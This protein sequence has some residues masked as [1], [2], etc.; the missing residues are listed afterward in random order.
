MQLCLKIVEDMMEFMEVAMVTNYRCECVS[1]HNLHRLPCHVHQATAQ[2]MTIYMSFAMFYSDPRTKLR[3][4][5][6]S[7]LPPWYRP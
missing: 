4:G 3:S 1:K 5:I 7:P 2:S 6:L